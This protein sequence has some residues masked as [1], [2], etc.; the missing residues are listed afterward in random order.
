[1]ASATLP[2]PVTIVA[3]E[4]SDDRVRFADADAG[5]GVEVPSAYA[6]RY[7]QSDYTPA[8][9]ASACR[10]E[11]PAMNITLDERCYATV[12]LEDG[13]DYV[14][15]DRRKQRYFRA[16]DATALRNGTGAEI[17]LVFTDAD[18]NVSSLGVY[19]LNAEGNLRAADTEFERYFELAVDQR[20]PYAAAPRPALVVRPR[21]L[22]VLNRTTGQPLANQSYLALD[23]FPLSNADPRRSLQF[24]VLA[25]EDGGE[26]NNAT[27]RA[28]AQLNFEV[29]AANLNTPVAAELVL[30]R[31]RLAADAP[32]MLVA[33][34]V[35]VI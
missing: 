19:A 25:L 2:V 3:S 30:G 31:H 4:A 22:A 24:F 5:F 27:Q 23:T 14:Q 32:L 7:A 8:L 15:R 12:R 26:A 11:D 10:A 35:I 16:E 21:V 1:M 9:S 13:R 33:N 28:L 17:G 29:A 20:Y 18:V 34:G 6:F